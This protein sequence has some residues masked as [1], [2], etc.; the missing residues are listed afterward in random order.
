MMKIP[1]SILNALAALLLAAGPVAAQAV[2]NPEP[3]GAAQTGKFPFSMAGQLVFKNGASYYQASGTVVWQ[4]S[5]LTAAHNLWSPESGWSTEMEFNRARSGPSI[6]S[7]QFATRLFIFGS[8]RSAAAQYGTDSVR[9]FANDLGGL[10]FSRMPASG[11]YAGWVADVTGLT[12]GPPAICLGYGAVIHTGND[13]LSV[14]SAAPFVQ[15]T[16]AFMEN[17]SL[18]FEEG[19]SGGPVFFPVAPDDLRIVGVVVAGSDTPPSGAIRAID[20]AGAAFITT[21]LHY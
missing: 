11:M 1:A 12:G 20:A 10:R 19:M 3:I 21:Y 15:A 8:Y 9:T 6:A 17:F 2:S 7:R 14:I 16:G 18:T 5:V 13:L 4:R